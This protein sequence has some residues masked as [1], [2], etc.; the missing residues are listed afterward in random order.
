MFDTT[1]SFAAHRSRFAVLAMS[2]AIVGCATNAIAP[3]PSVAIPAAWHSEVL[4][5]ANQMTATAAWW[6]NAGSPELATL[7]EQ[8]LR[9]NRDLRAAAARVLQARAIAGTADSERQPQV[10]GTASASR[11][12]ET[13]LDPRSSHLRAGLQAS[14]ELDLFG[15][16]AL[17]SQ[18]AQL[19][20]ERAELARQGMETVIAAEVA[21]AYLDA[22][23][24]KERMNIAEQ[25]LDKLSQAT[26]VAR[27][28]FE[29]GR[30]ARP[31]IVARERQ[32]QAAQADLTQLESV[33]RLR[34]FQ[35]SILVGV[36]AGEINPAF[37]GLEN[38]RLAAPPGTLP[39]ELLERRPD[40]QQHL[41][42]VNAEAARVGMSRRELYP[43]IV[44]S[45]D[46][47]QERAGIEGTS[48]TTG[49]ALGYG[50][51]L[52]LP[53]LDGGRIRSRI[54]VSEATLEEAMAG[55]E[56]AML[57]ALADAETVLVRQKSAAGVLAS[58]EESLQLS[59]ENAAQA[60]RL[61]QAGQADRGRTI[62]SDLSV[63]QAE[64]AQL[65]AKG[66]YWSASVDVLRAF[67]GSI[68]TP[69]PI[70]LAPSP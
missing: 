36:P 53:I 8:A 44:F 31:E 52:T 61:F 42:A 50:V 22:A 28:Q 21:T 20:A 54:E 35:L 69:N 37:A 23:I 2:L 46:N 63:L 16:K 18:A 3:S 33:F 14:W 64:D 25:S 70:A 1:H 57:D 62:D 4:S 34:L 66:A 59:G 26:R 12:R 5:T 38:L 39:G 41:R 51:S 56:K 43:R 17:A 68:V 7:I 24:L 9:D 55:Y 60:R 10:N 65:Q 58:N 47:S 40:V 48:S 27:S 11:G 49:V 19:D 32:Y 45:W 13:V 15:A 30:L 29:A 67:S 6:K